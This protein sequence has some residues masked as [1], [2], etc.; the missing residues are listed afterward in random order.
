MPAPTNERQALGRELREELPARLAE[1]QRELTFAPPVTQE[2]REWL[3]WQIRRVQKRM[4]D[5]KARLAGS[6]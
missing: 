3:V 1:Y 6:G 5:V 4:G 2:R